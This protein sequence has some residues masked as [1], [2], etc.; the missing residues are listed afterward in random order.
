MSVDFSGYSGFRHDIT[1][2]LLKVVLNTISLAQK[3]RNVTSAKFCFTFRQST[4]FGWGIANALV[5]KKAKVAL[6]LDRCH[7]FLSGAA[8]IMKETLDFFYSISIILHEVYGMSES[9]GKNC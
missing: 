9:T 2:I 4:P 5:F 8:P 3:Y 1:E 6:G 7:Y